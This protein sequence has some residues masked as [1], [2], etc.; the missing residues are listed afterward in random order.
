MRYEERWENNDTQLYWDYRLEDPDGENILSVGGWKEADEPRNSATLK[1]KPKW[2]IHPAVFL[3]RLVKIPLD[4]NDLRSE[5][6]IVIDGF[7]WDDVGVVSKRIWKNDW[8]DE[9]YSTRVEYQFIKEDPFSGRRDWDYFRSEHEDGVIKIK[10]NDGNIL[11]YNYPSDAQPE[12]LSDAMGAGFETLIDAVINQLSMH[13]NTDAPMFMSGEFASLG[14]GAVTWSNEYDPSQ[15]LVGEL[16]F[17]EQPNEWGDRGFR[18][19]FERPDGE[20]LI[21]FGGNVS[22]DGSGEPD[23]DYAEV[24]VREFI[25]KTDLETGEVNQS[26]LDALDRCG[27]TDSLVIPEDVWA[28]VQMIEPGRGIEPRMASLLAMAKVKCRRI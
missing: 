22:V 11:G 26:W 16:N 5:S 8:N 2:R 21:E 13:D 19:K 15:T 18:I 24:N 9:G 4:W 14:G 10:D 23:Y 3:S 12:S 6:E 1:D 27:P 17:D 20:P 28:N 7:N 25:Y